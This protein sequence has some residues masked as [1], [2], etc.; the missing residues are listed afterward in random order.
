MRPRLASKPRYQG[1]GFYSDYPCSAQ[2]QCGF[3]VF[4]RWTMRW[5]RWARLARAIL[6][7]ARRQSYSVRLGLRVRKRHCCCR[8]STANARTRRRRPHDS[9]RECTRVHESACRSCSLQ[10]GSAESDEALESIK[11]RTNRPG[12]VAVVEDAW[13]RI[14]WA[15]RQGARSNFES[16]LRGATSWA[17]RGGGDG[18]S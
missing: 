15:H 8:D 5:P 2:W 1:S 6:P 12:A 16:A 18:R 13:T 9:A 14:G 3:A 10:L 7:P 11:E 17:P 4:Y